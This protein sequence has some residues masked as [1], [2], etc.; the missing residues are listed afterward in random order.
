M[1]EKVDEVVLV[2][3]QDLLCL[4]MLVPLEEMHEWC[5]SWKSSFIINFLGKK[6]SFRYFKTKLDKLCITKGGFQFIYIDNGYYVTRFSEKD[7]YNNVL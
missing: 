3:N 4:I 5:K 1:E 7:D 2:E 6:I